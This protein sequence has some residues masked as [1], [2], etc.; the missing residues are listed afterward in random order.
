VNTSTHPINPLKA[1]LAEDKPG[2]GMLVSMPSVTTAQILAAAGF[3][4][5][6]F[7]MEHGPID[8][9]SV[10]A[11][12]TATQ[13]TRATPIVRVPWNLPWLVK[14]VLDAG[15]MGI[16][17][18]MI[19]NRAE[20]EAAAKSVRYPPRGNRGF[21]PFYGPARF[22]RSRDEYVDLAD[23]QILCMLLIEHR[24][25]ID[26]IREIVNVPGVDACHIAPNDL[27]MS[28]GYRDGPDH[29]EVQ[30][31]IGRAEEVILAGPTYL[32]GLALD[33]ATANQMIGRG[34]RII[35]AGSDTLLLERGSA[36]ILGGIDRGD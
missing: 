9:A 14:P 6:F 21:G 30:D 5:L 11:M 18:P 22:G 15:A 7:D 32:G 28:Y 13:G 29:Q 26:N 10:H 35:L 1:R 31:A 3:D 8:L 34:Y 36:D 23:E 16:V 25:A 17:F 24:E 4:W 33:N 27:A 12:V 19:H 2:I 20:A